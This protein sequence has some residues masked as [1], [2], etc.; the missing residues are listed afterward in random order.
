MNN[1]T[2]PATATHPSLLWPEPLRL[3]LNARP[4]L[5]APFYERYVRRCRDRDDDGICDRRDNCLDCAN[6]SQRDF[7]LDGLGD[8]CDPDDDNDGDPD[9][10]DPSPY[11]AGVTSRT[12]AAAAAAYHLA[13]SISQ[14]A[15]RVDLL[16]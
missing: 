11:N 2:H 15:P 13:S 14:A 1:V 8:P 10:T 9:R 16:A 12:Q 4:W 6:P 7:D 5:Q 3:Q